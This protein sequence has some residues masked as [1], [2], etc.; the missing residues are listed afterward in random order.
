VIRTFT[1]IVA[2]LAVIVVL[3]GNACLACWTPIQKSAGTCCNENTS[4]HK[5]SKAPARHAHDDCA[6]T[7]TD[8]AGAEQPPSSSSKLIVPAEEPVKELLALTPPSSYKVAEQSVSPYYPPD[9]C[10]LN[11]VL[12]I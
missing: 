2:A 9:L 5:P 11:S 10:L 8:V 7:P 1:S 6:T 4:C 3:T 12:T